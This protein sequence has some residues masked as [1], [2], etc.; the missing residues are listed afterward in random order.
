[1]CFSDEEGAEGW[2]FVSF[3]LASLSLSQR[4][5]AITFAGISD[6]KMQ[7]RTC[8]S[9]LAQ[10]QNALRPICRVQR[11]FIYYISTS[12]TKKACDHHHPEDMCKEQCCS[13]RQMLVP[14]GIDIID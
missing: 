1:M 3:A 14:S 10:S 2:P 6:Q 12:Q 5:R 13:P 11:M 8:S 4:N 7:N 9:Q